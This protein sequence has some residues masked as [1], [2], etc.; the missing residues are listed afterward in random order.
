MKP[1]TKRTYRSW[2]ELG[3]DLW[4]VLRLS[5]RA[6]ALLRGRLV[7]AQFRQRLMLAVTAVND[8]RYCSYAHTR[9]ALKAGLSSEEISTLL[10]GASGS[11]VMPL[12]APVEEVPAILYAQHWAETNGIPDPEA[13]LRLA[14]LYGAQKQQVIE[15]SLLVIHI[16]N[17]LGNWWDA[18]MYRL[19]GQG[20]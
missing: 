20:G 5:G 14:E 17:K 11:P 6:G 8:C 1:G 15:L 10:A 9:L 2:S 4:A 16:A 18:W 13:K 7:N 3:R 12:Q 19:R